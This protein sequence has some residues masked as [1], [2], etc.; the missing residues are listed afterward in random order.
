MPPDTAY[1]IG[2]RAT[3]KTTVGRLAADILGWECV[4]LDAEIEARRGVTCAELVS[5]DRER[6]RAIERETLADLLADGPYPGD[7]DADASTRRLVVLGAGYHS[8]DGGLGLPKPGPCI[9][10][11]RDGWEDSAADERTQV[12][13]EMPPGAEFSWMRATREP[14]WE[15]AAHLRLD[16]PR[17]RDADSTARQLATYLDWL[18]RLSENDI[19]SRSWLVPGTAAE[20]DRI[21]RDLHWLDVAGVELRSDL[22]QPVP[23]QSDFRGATAERTALL[24]LPREAGILASVR[25]A[26]PA[27][28]R[29]L[30]WVDA[31]DVD[32]RHLDVLVDADVLEERPPRPLLLS[33][34]PSRPA[35]EVAEQLI[36]AAKTVVS[37][38]PTWR[39]Y[40]T[41]KYAPAVGDCEE[42]THTLRHHR[43]LSAAGFPVTV[44]PQGERFAWW[45]PILAT[46]NATNY[47][48]VGLGDRRRTHTASALSLPY[49]LQDWLPHLAGPSPTEFDGLVGE[50][51]ADT[52]GDLW[53]RRAALRENRDQPTTTPSRSYLKIPAGRDVDD[54]ELGALLKTLA[55]A[56]PIRGLS[57]TSPLKRRVA[58]VD[59]VRN[60]KELT[61]CNTLRRLP[62]DHHS[63]TDGPAES[64]VATDT[65]RA[66]MSAVLERAESAGVPPGTIAIIGRGGV[67]PA[68]RRA[69]D[70]SDWQLLHHASGRVGWNDRRPDLVDMVINAAGNHDTPYE[71]APTCRVWVDLHYTDVRPLPTYIAEQVELHLNGDLFFEA[72][73]EAQRS[74]WD[75]G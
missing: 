39:G 2:H 67:A 48:P 69:I 11:H 64:W 1:I 33:A 22:H 21:R 10:L 16:I 59:G 3:G 66:G 30:G 75:T 70:A 68:L 5:E 14:R 40:L 54:G 29:S 73:A 52:Q 58:A 6:F 65:D 32:L 20:F 49:D 24:D 28:L 36:T 37:D 27:W 8:E 63:D 62:S 42:L 26:D 35:A 61:A 17:G 57:V 47:L 44:L 13:P 53:H 51:V 18:T 56:L 43:L 7:G 41:L 23:D 45:R 71:G 19:A 74:F 4:D 38:Y 15:R 34:H 25:T 9:W 12:R 31:F 72:Q 55:D 46:T 60:P 50:P